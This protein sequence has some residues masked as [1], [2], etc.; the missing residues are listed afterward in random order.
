LA[1]ETL[2]LEGAALKT[3]GDEEV[4]LIATLFFNY[5]FIYA[6]FFKLSLAFV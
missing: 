3:A 4:S 5:S 6:L 1:T 2:T